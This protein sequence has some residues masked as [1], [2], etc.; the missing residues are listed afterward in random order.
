LWPLYFFFPPACAADTANAALFLAAHAAAVWCG[1]VSGVCV[2]AFLWTTRL[3]HR[4]EAEPK[5]T[6]ANAALLAAAAFAVWVYPALR[7][8]LPA[9]W[10][11]AISA[12][13]SVCVSALCGRV[14]TAAIM[15]NY[16][17]TSH[18]IRWFVGATASM[19][20]AVLA[21]FGGIDYAATYLVAG[22][23]TALALRGIVVATITLVLVVVRVS[24]CY[25][26]IRDD[27][28]AYSSVRTREQ[29]QR[30]HLFSDPFPL[31]GAGGG[32]ISSSSV[33]PHYEYSSDDDD[34]K[35]DDDYVEYDDNNRGAE[36]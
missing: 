32:G 3:L 5:S 20:L 18:D 24:P 29:R 25:R 9:P 28:L 2:G 12:A 17:A 8:A 31:N 26:R 35:T 19:A 23:S 1:S 14:W 15:G 27:R 16:F 30:Q 7:G 34:R 33:S 36:T 10:P 4:R 21:L 11:I 22:G 13:L 6:V